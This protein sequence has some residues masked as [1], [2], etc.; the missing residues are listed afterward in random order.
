MTRAWRWI[1]AIC[2]GLT[3]AGT[4][5]ARNATTTQLAITG[6]PVPGQKITLTATLSGGPFLVAAPNGAPGGTLIFRDG[7]TVIYQVRITT[8]T[9]K[10]TY[11]YYDNVPICYSDG[12]C[13][14]VTYRYFLATLAAAS[15]DY[16]LPN[17]LGTRSFSVQFSVDDKFSTGSASGPV[18][19]NPKYPN[20]RP[21]ID[22]LL[23]D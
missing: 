21:A 12:S 1:A 14:T 8:S 22:L 20:I 4:A 9:A 2:L 16:K 3:F 23:N 19:V 15:F 13:S 7:D 11:V 18:S 17:Q 6:K 10:N 5:T